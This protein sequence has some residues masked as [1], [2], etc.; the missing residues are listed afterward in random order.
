VG[1]VSRRPY[2]FCCQKPARLK[3]SHGLNHGWGRGPDA[4]D[5]VKRFRRTTKHETVCPVDEAIFRLP[6]KL[7]ETD[8]R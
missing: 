7:L 8:P 1:G 6:R 5:P 3:Q 2:W 4:L